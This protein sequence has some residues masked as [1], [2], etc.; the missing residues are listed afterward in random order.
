M[1]LLLTV[2]FSP[3]AVTAPQIVFE[4]RLGA[5]D[6]G[7]DCFMSIDGTNFHILQKGAATRGNAFGSHKY[8]RKSAL[9]Y[10]LGI[11]I[12]AGNLVWIGGP[13]LA[14]KWNDNFFY[15]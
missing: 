12:L 8:A 9:C 6:V 13:Y 3:P 15:E 10:K 7:N 4:S 2:I 14:G 1:A 5:H 11:D